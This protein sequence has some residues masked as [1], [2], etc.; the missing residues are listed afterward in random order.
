MAKIDDQ[1]FT[2]TSVYVQ[3]PR[4]EFASPLKSVKVNE[5]EHACL[6][7]ELN[8]KDAEVEWWKE[9]TKIKVTRFFFIFLY[10]EKSVSLKLFSVGRQKM[11][12]TESWSKTKVVGQK[13]WR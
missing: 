13:L 10:Q 12:R 5:K 6:E 1:T 7:C 8:D 2:K 3:E 9:D 11:G 4:F